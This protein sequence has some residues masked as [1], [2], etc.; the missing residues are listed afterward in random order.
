MLIYLRFGCLEDI[1]RFW[2][3]QVQ[4]LLSNG[5]LLAQSQTPEQN[6][7]SVES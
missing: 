3:F 1:M 4:P 2:E 7:K 6:I 5:D